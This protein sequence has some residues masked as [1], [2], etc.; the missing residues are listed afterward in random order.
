MSA[1]LAAWMMLAAADYS[2]I[3]V[4]MQEF[5]E[6]GK[7][8]GSVALVVRQGKVVHLSAAGYQDLETKRPMRTD[9]IFQIMSM[10]KPVTAVALMMLVEEG[11]G[12]PL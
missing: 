7:V 1:V 12:Q 3:L 8:A 11:A 5:A 10:T 9:S 6:A 2:S 4:R